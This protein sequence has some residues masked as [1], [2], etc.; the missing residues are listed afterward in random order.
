VMK[1]TVSVV[2]ACHLRLPCCRI[3]RRPQTRQPLGAHRR[4]R[5]VGHSLDD[6]IEF[7]SP[8][9]RLVAW[10]GT[11]ILPYRWTH[12]LGIGAGLGIRKT[13]P[14]PPSSSIPIP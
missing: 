10:R 9:G 1:R 11:S 13:C 12:G 3:G 5:E 2:A 6:P 7:Q 4:Q 8:P 14:T